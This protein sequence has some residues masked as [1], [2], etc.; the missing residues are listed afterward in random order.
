ML[1]PLFLTGTLAFAMEEEHEKARSL[2]FC[3]VVN[4]EEVN[5]D[6][7]L[8]TIHGKSLSS[9]PLSKE[10]YNFIISKVGSKN[11]RPFVFKAGPQI[12]FVD[13]VDLR[14]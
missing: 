11:K 6:Q 1:M 5:Y 13:E 3:E 9:F 12:I 8:N 4:N 2:H 10:M 14:R 7:K